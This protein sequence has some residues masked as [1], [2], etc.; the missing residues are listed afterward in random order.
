MSEKNYDSTI[1]RIAGNILSGSLSVRNLGNEALHKDYVEQIASD[2]VRLA[3]AVVAEVLRT[4][5][6][7][8]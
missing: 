2:A 7:K 6:P 4:S 5:E 1:M 3:R 8:P